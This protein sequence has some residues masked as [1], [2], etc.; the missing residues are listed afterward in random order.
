MADNT[1]DTLVIKVEGTDESAGSTLDKVIQKLESIQQSTSG[2]SRRVSN[3]T[4]KLSSLKATV[5]NLK[6]QKLNLFSDSKVP[7]SVK[8]TTDSLNHLKE[9]VNDL[10]GTETKV[11]S[12]E[13]VSRASRFSDKLSELK[14][15]VSGLRNDTKSLGSQMKDTFSN[16]I[17]GR[18]TSGIKGI[19]S[20]LGRIAMYRLM[21]SIIKQV[22]D[23]F[24]TGIDNIYQYSKAFNGQF[25]QDMDSAASSMLTFK[26]SIGAVM[27]PII[28]LVV[29]WLDKVVDKIIDINNTAAMVIAG[30]SGKS[31]YSKAVR[32]TTE[33]AA[34]A[35]K[36]SNKTEKVKNKVE[37]LKRSL[38]GLD[39]ITVIGDLDTATSVDVPVNDN[40]G[41]INTPNYSSMFVETPVNMAKV[42][43]IVSKFKKIWEIA[44]WIGIAIAAWKLVSFI[45]S[46]AQA[47]SSLGT[48]SKKIVGLTLMIAGFS[49]EFAGAKDIGKNGLNLKNA[50]MTAIGAALGVAGSLLVFGT[51]PL[52]WTIGLTVALTV[53]I[54]GYLKGKWEKAKELYEL[55]EDYKELSRIISESERISSQA[56]GALD[57][58]TD[59]KKRF[60]ETVGNY[61]A[62]SALV[63][64]IFNLY[65]KSGL[66]STELE[67]LKIKVETLNNL[68][69]DGLRLE[70]DETKGVLFQVSE[71]ADGTTEKIEA[72]RTSVSNLMDSLQEEA[73]TAAM[74]EILTEAYKGYYQALINDETAST[75]VKTATEKLEKAQK[76]LNDRYKEVT[77]SSDALN[78]VSLAATGTSQ[79]L[80]AAAFMVSDEYWNLKVRVDEAQEAVDKATAAQAENNK[81]LEESKKN[82]DSTTSALVGLKEKGKDYANNPLQS[83]V[84]FDK[85]LKTSSDAVSKLNDNTTS[86]AKDPTVKKF[87]NFA[88]ASTVNFENSIKDS[89]I[90]MQSLKEE[91]TGFR[92]NNYV[93]NF[94][95][96]AT[97]SG[98]EL[99]RSLTQASKDADRLRQSLQRI[100]GFSGSYSYTYSFGNAPKYATGGFPED[101][102]FFAN[103][104]E[105]VGQFSNGKTAVANNEQI[106]DGIS[107]G[108]ASANREQNAL[109]REQNGLLRRLLEKDSSID[110]S[111]IAKA[112]NQKN[113][114]DGKV[115]VPVAT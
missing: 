21:R 115:T 49:L 47:I 42:N 79:G 91:A 39:E 2:S 56:A 36:A 28:S 80:A 59:A 38:A 76:D 99:S 18:F 6:P 84:A 70:F 15:H 106:V 23:S 35:D 53:G 3:F 26:N 93:S 29:P 52:G 101:G 111:T 72:T 94:A 95:A 63:N 8:Q 20:T 96:N 108:V 12:D 34:A 11:V 67:L 43:E 24:K 81:T 77:G 105:L 69:L 22:T 109:L 51:G 74:M 30:L 17:I 62:A 85:G 55:T 16:T 41:N 40:N 83:T 64:E 97:Q 46:I 13:S 88:N 78:M 65:E 73:Q 114:R 86:F 110:V 61:L 10:N 37:E 102:F 5:D 57:S 44:K 98:N 19:F 89:Q 4:K 112:F 7:S 104:N 25:S 92:S 75:N 14:N 1:I 33:Y 45:S 58:L 32:V 107:E 31:T 87:T 27:A 66:S 71:N 9:T 54:V 90:R 82:I 48:L 113:R 50:L 100:D 68:G 103:H 60:D